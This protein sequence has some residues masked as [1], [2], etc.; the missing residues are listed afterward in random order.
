M[1]QLKKQLSPIGTTE[2]IDFPDDAIFNVPAKID[3]G[4]DYS[5][6]WASD[7]VLED[8]MLRFTFFGP[9]SEY[10]DKGKVVHTDSFKVARVKNSFGQVELRYKVKIR[11]RIGSKKLVRWCN[12]ADRSRSTFPVLLGKNFL[13]NVFMVDVS[14]RYIASNSVVPQTVL[15]LAT[16]DSTEFMKQVAGYMK[17]AATITPATYK[18]LVYQVNGLETTVLYQTPL[19]STDLATYDMVYFKSHNK[20]PELAGAAAEYLVFRGRRFADKELASYTSMSKLT[21]YVKL[22]CAGVPVPKSFCAAHEY[23][24]ANFGHLSETLGLPF[25]LKEIA[26]DRG[27][28][29]YFIQTEADFQKVLAGA[30]ATQQYLAQAYIPNDGFFRLYV[31][32]KTVELGIWRETYPHADPLK[33]HL[34]K[35]KGGANAKKVQYGNIPAAAIELAQKASATMNRQIAG[36]DVLQDKATGAWYVLEVNSGPQLRTGSYVDEKAHMLAEYLD[37][38]LNR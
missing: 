22:S 13:K 21:E 38:E 28:N 11:V 10:Y 7:V 23:L 25:V 9:G 17:E 27:K 19:Q 16:Q 35:P 1:T 37:K 33:A 6:I 34:N 14:G 8:E 18:D 12:L 24:A 31:A 5:A 4:A 26:S 20:A 32:G 29:N 3:T 30:L 15:V 36:V 2:L